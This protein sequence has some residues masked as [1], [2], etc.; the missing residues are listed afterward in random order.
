[1]RSDD[2]HSARA[3]SSH[4]VIRCPN[5][6]L[7]A[8]FPVLSTFGILSMKLPP[9]IPHHPQLKENLLSHPNASSSRQFSKDCTQRG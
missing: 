9:P 3:L 5:K 6:A 2:S 8:Y 1:M 7:V 4:T